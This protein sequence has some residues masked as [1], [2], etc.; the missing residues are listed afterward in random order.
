LEEYGVATGWHY[1]SDVNQSLRFHCHFNIN[2]V[3]FA[4]GVEMDLKSI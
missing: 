4:S 3:F 2:A 1:S